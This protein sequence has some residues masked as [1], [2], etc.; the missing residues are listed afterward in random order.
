MFIILTDKATS[1]ELVA[2]SLIAYSPYAF[3]LSSDLLGGRSINLKLEMIQ[4]DSRLFID[5][6]IEAVIE[7]HQKHQQ[8]TLYLLLPNSIRQY[9]NCQK[10]QENSSDDS[11]QYLIEQLKNQNINIGYS[12][13][14]DN[15]EHNLLKTIRIS[16]S[17]DL[18]ENK[19]EIELN[20]DGLTELIRQ[21]S[22]VGV[23]LHTIFIMKILADLF[24][25][26]V[27]H[28]KP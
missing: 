11:L 16:Y 12:S 15:T 20:I 5:R 19:E 25:K 24:H 17:F 26:N 2:E 22:R 1:H 13:A 7:K 18:D 27:K 10:K 21:S 23:S 28:T 9:L 6:F 14:L 8:K 3:F 4:E